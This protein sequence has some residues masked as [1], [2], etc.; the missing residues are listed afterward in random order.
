MS[1][2][3]KQICLMNIKKVDPTLE[4]VT[5]ISCLQHL[6]EDK[7]IST[8]MTL[9]ADMNHDCTIAWLHNLSIFLMFFQPS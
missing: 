3:T 6:Y 2:F 5:F 8:F 7:V 4:D 1:L 9:K